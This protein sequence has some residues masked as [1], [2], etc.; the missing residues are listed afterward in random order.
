M[1]IAACDK[2][3]YA[4]LGC[5]EP[6]DNC[7]DNLHAGL[8]GLGLTAPR[9]PCPLNL[10]MNVPV[11]DG[12]RFTYEARPSRPGGAVMFRAAMDLVIAFSACPQDILPINGVDRRP[13]EAHFTV[14]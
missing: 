11:H 7:T 8:H 3:R 2:Y 14:A 6:H 5:T 12:N 10:F 9:T 1:L 13:T 4:Q